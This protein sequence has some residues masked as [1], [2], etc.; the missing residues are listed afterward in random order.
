MTDIFSIL[1][2]RRQPRNPLPRDLGQ[3]C[4]KRRTSLPDHGPTNQREN[5]HHN[6]QQQADGASGAG[7]RSAIRVGG[8]M[9]LSVAGVFKVSGTSR[10]SIST[11][12]V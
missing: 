3:E 10:A 1:G 8:R 9:L 5:G 4:L 6:R 7:D 2:I 12:I 11:Q